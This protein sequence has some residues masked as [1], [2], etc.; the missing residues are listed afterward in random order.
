MQIH[1]NLLT[2]DACYSVINYN[3]R[4]GWGTGEGMWGGVRSRQWCHMLTHLWIAWVNFLTIT[5]MQI[6]ILIVTSRPVKS[7]Y[8]FSF[9]FLH[10]GRQEALGTLN[11]LQAHGIDFAKLL[12]EYDDDEEDEADDDG[13]ITSRPGS[14]R[15]RAGSKKSRAGSLK[16]E[17]GKPYQCW[18][19]STCIEM[20]NGSVGTKEFKRG[21]SL[22]LWSLCNAMGMSAIL[23]VMYG[24]WGITVPSDFARTF[25]A[26]CSN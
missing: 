17:V 3:S 16:K 25:S 21:T 14:I 7:S 23:T 4:V 5:L 19:H 8:L 13:L 18:K 22:S 26:I 24:G 15:S 10:Q 12:K 2:Y 11:E 20:N 6:C 9:L 1:H